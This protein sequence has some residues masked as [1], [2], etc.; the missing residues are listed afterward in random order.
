ME[1]FRVVLTGGGS[2]GHIYPLIAVT[3]ALQA[4]LSQLNAPA[5]S[6][7]LGPKDPY[8]ALLSERGIP[9]HPIDPEKCAV[10]F[11]FKIFWTRQNFL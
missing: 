9:I 3:E 11:P 4:R 2:G 6:I 5:E 10:I 8:S 1:K 7:Y